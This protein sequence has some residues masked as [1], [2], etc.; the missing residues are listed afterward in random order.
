MLRCDEGRQQGLRS[1]TTRR[2]LGSRGSGGIK[3]SCSTCSNERR[4][5]HKLPSLLL[6][7]P[8]HSRRRIDRARY[9][10]QSCGAAVSGAA[11]GG[12]RAAVA[13][14]TRRRDG[15]VEA[16]GW[17]QA[18]LTAWVE[19]MGTPT[20]PPQ[21][22][23]RSPPPPPAVDALRRDCI[24][25]RF[26][27]AVNCDKS[28]LEDYAVFLAARSAVSPPERRPRDHVRENASAHPGAR[29]A[30]RAFAKRSPKVQSSVLA[31]ARAIGWRTPPRKPAAREWRVTSR[32]PERAPRPPRP[33]SFLDAKRRQRAESL[34]AR[35][36]RA[37]DERPRGRA[38]RACS[39]RSRRRRLRRR[40]LRPRRRHPRP[41][42]AAAPRRRSRRPAR[43][44]PCA[45]C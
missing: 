29:A 38:P 22:Q 12:R 10:S 28:F 25:E 5:A 36:R 40:S 43:T 4:S 39:T 30:A 2:V 17:Q 37:R 9:A 11:H 15:A 33:P 6:L 42:T 44:P 35:R 32:S 34:P 41:R 31:S 14:S 26:A 45:P 7:E 23:Q 21:Q 13:E 27:A 20:P 8:W 16:L 19:T 24:R 18:E 1:V 3:R